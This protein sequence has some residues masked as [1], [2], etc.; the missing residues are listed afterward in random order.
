MSSTQS[1]L[2]LRIA[3]TPEVHAALQAMKSRTGQSLKQCCEMVLHG[4]A[5]QWIESAE[6]MNAHLIARGSP[7]VG[8]GSYRQRVDMANGLPKSMPEGGE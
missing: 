8:S 1:D 5:L 7:P 3:M 6:V 2:D 4:W